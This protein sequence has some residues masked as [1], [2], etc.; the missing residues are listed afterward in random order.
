[1]MAPVMTDV[2][3]VYDECDHNVMRSASPHVCRARSRPEET[4][5]DKKAK[6]AEG[7]VGF[8]VRDVSVPTRKVMIGTGSPREFRVRGG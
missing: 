6:N 8:A 3:D 2:P 7:C 5:A 4:R 1:M